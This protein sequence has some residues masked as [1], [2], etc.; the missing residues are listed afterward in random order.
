MV[1]VFS[2]NGAA[3][4]QLDPQEPDVIGQIRCFIPAVRRGTIQTDAG[5]CVPFCIPEGAADL[6]GGDIVE[7]DPAAG[8]QAPVS[9]VTLRRRWA[10]QLNAEHRPLVNQFHATIRIRY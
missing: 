4:H 9:R 8:R 5:D 6:Q 3:L 1:R 2:D 7:F 10:D